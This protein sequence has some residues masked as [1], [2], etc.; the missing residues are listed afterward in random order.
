MSTVR[1]T[2]QPNAWPRVFIDGLIVENVTAIAYERGELNLTVCPDDLA[3]DGVTVVETREHQWQ[4]E[5]TLSDLN[6]HE[7]CMC[8]GRTRTV[9]VECEDEV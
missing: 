3:L 9:K 1:I 6:E 4:S 2:K 7:R 8:C 5:R